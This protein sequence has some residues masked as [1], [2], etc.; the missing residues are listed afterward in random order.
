[1]FSSQISPPCPALPEL[2]LV[3]CKGPALGFRTLNVPSSGTQMS[4]PEQTAPREVFEFI[5]QGR[6]IL[7][8]SFTE[9]R[10]GVGEGFLSLLIICASGLVTQTIFS[11][12][13]K[14]KPEN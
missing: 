6:Y 11:S 8:E 10:S 1:M 13:S 4:P 12:P 2:S 3:R 7:C 14:S 9:Q 5:V